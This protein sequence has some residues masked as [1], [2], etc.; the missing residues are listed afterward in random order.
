M[1]YVVKVVI[2]PVHPR[3]SSPM[4]SR[5]SSMTT[6]FPR[7]TTM[8]SLSRSP[9][10]FSSTASSRTMLRKTCRVHCQPN[11][12]V[13]DF[14]PAFSPPICLSL[15]FYLP[16][17]FL[18]IP[19]ALGYGK[20]MGRLAKTY[21]ISSQDAHDFAVSIQLDEEPLLHILYPHHSSAS[22]TLEEKPRV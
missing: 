6:E 21:I 1:L 7:M 22:H 17:V 2:S 18:S 8:P 16:L 3:R 13:V 14:C 9:L 20:Q 5:A 10:G 4:R 11:F 12:R 19:S 15:S